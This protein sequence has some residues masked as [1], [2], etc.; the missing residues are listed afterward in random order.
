MKGSSFVAS[1]QCFSSLGLFTVA[2]NM[3]R[4]FGYRSRCTSEAVYAA[5]G[6]WPLGER[7][8]THSVYNYASCEV[9]Q[10]WTFLLL[11]C[12]IYLALISDAYLFFYLCAQ[13]HLGRIPRSRSKGNTASSH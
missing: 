9:R 2:D 5:F 7:A 8:F 6:I 11:N 3:Q 12:K 13:E 1:P 10:G 4:I